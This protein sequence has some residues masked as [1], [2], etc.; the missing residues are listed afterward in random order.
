MDGENECF[1]NGKPLFIECHCCN[2]GSHNLI[3]EYSIEIVTS[4]VSDLDNSAM[5]LYVQPVRG[6]LWKRIIYAI[7]HI[8]NFGNRRYEAIHFT[9]EYAIEFRKYLE[10]FIK[11]HDDVVI[12]FHK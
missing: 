9:K 11:R 10:E 3:A 6:T 12:S 1:E 2:C 4:A 7:G 5:W 8:F